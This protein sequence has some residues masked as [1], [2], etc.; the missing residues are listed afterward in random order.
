MNNRF[1]IALIG[2]AS[3]IWTPKFL[4]D[5][6][7]IEEL[8]GSEICLMDIDEPS[9][10][11]MGRLG[12]R[13]LTELGKDFSLTLT[14]DRLEAIKGAHVV[15][16]TLLIGGHD[17]WCDDLNII[18]SYG[19]EHPK[20]M[21]VGP[22]GLIQ[23]LKNI[24]PLVQ[25]AKEM[26]EHCPNAWF[27][28]YTNPMQSI[29]L[30]LQ[31][32]SRVRS[33]G[34]CHGVGE[35]IGNISQFLEIDQS[36]LAYKAFGLNHCGWLFELRADG[37][38]VLPQLR[39]RLDEVA[40]S[41]K[42][43]WEGQEI[44]TREMWDVFGAYPLQADIHTIEFFPH[45]FSAKNTKMESYS[46]EHNFVEKR[47]ENRQAL[48][49]LVQEAA[50][51][52]IPIEKAIGSTA[53][54]SDITY[55]SEEKLD[56]LLRAILLNRPA[57]MYINTSNRGAIPNLP[58]N[59]CIEVPGLV[60]ALNAYPVAVGPLPDGIAGILA[61]HAHIQR[62]TVEAA[63]SGSREHALQA[64]YLEPMCASLSIPEL[65][66]MLDELLESQPEWVPNFF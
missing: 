6:F 19:I 63:M 37:K 57:T 12:N 23:G 28:N 45:Y 61:P 49:K 1:K 20:G 55:T 4:R 58:S 44:A 60:D 3:M 26:E 62:L 33:I 24:P 66:A 46:L 9:L 25:L 36:R 32:Y 48:W 50:R 10:D 38:D 22:G 13:M 64:L 52:E 30:A 27:L 21:S 35:G 31:E 5:I 18:R 41:L 40:P 8:K 14:T 53:N 29:T 43:R 11:V 42:G 7:E 15:V 51:G 17:T 34:L 47:I 54:P 2:G 59:C 56:E 16:S 39:K 65:R